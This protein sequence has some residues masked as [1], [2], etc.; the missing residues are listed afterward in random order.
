V[1]VEYTGEGICCKD[2]NIEIDIF[3]QVML[4]LCNL[5][6]CRMAFDISGLHI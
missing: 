1:T 5:R 3:K 6:L 2:D 4:I